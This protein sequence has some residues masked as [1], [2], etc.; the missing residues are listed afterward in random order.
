MRIT[1]LELENF[2]CFEQMK[3]ELHPEFTLLV[4]INGS[5]KTA[6]LEALAI[7]VSSWLLGLRLTVGTRTAFSP[8]EPR[9]VKRISG[10]VPSLEIA[11]PTRVSAKAMCADSAL[12]GTL[13]SE[14]PQF[15]EVLPGLRDKGSVAAD[16]LTAEQ[17]VE[18][19]VIAY[20]RTARLWQSRQGSQRPSAG[21]VLEGYSDCLNSSTGA[22]LLIEWMAWRESVKLQEIGRAVESGLPVTSVREPLL[23]AVANAA[24]ACVEGAT[25]FYY[26]MNHQELRIDFADGR[27]LPFNLLSDGTRNLL[28][29]A[30]DIAWRAARLNPHHGAD[31]AKKATGVVLIDEIDLHLHPT[32]QRR[33]IPDLRR[34]FPGIQFV[35]TTHSPQV[36]STAKPEWIRILHADGRVETVTHTLGRDSN[37]LLEDVFEVSE[38]PEKTRAEI[39]ALFDLIDRGALDE[40]EA[41]WAMLHEQLGPDDPDLVRA[42]TMLDLEK[43]PLLPDGDG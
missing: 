5:G 42:Q 27:T 13:D 32:W 26:S 3:L 35:A 38:R 31:A 2:R 8:A 24:L 12:S 28:A 18:L 33:V 11:R 17:I 22:K 36:L 4:G 14:R 6:V 21:S 7:V 37:S 40:A 34:A 19:P 1:T 16:A 25:R 20:Y 41:K 39:A 23:D 15:R 30:G 43:M 10:G 9:R 29:L